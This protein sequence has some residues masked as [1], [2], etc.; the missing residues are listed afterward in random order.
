[1]GYGM[2]GPSPG[3]S[4]PTGGLGGGDLGVI[5]DIGSAVAGE[6]VG[7]IFDYYGQKSANSANAL[8]AQ[9]N[10]DFQRDIF[11]T[12]VYENRRQIQ[13]QRDYNTKMANTAYQRSMADMQKA[14]LNPMLA[15]SQ[16]GASTPS[17][18]LPTAGGV[19]GDSAR[20]ENALGGFGK[21]LSKSVSTALQLKTIERELK[22][23]DSDVL[24]QDA[25][26]RKNAADTVLSQTNAQSVLV[27]MKKTR[28]EI[29]KLGVDTDKAKI[30][31]Q[32]LDFERQLYEWNKEAFKDNASY[33][34]KAAE[35]RNSYG[36]VWID[37]ILSKLPGMSN[38]G[39]FNRIKNW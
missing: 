25:L 31:K 4:L 11:R 2:T 30:D 27:N 5:G 14:G 17:S 3:G 37:N 23:T 36:Q 24:L 29:E 18:S 15:F 22:K 16:G 8:E 33:N 12:Q 28:A 1:M 34:K 13:S 39:S 35:A 9:R 6:I 38:A 26:A 21:G 32:I 10:R 7:G 20:M 19:S